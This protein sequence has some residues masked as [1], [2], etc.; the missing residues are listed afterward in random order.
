MKKVGR[1]GLIILTVSVLAAVQVHAVS[2]WRFG[3][4]VQLIVTTTNMGEV[5]VVRSTGEITIRDPRGIEFQAGTFDVEGVVHPGEAVKV[6]V[7]W[8]TSVA[9][10]NSSWVPGYFD[11]ILDGELAYANGEY[12][13][14]HSE[15]DDA[16]RL[17]LGSTGLN[18][19]PEI[20]YEGD[21]TGITQLS[22]TYYP[23]GPFMV[24]VWVENTGSTLF[25]PEVNVS[26]TCEDDYTFEPEARCYY[27]DE[28]EPGMNQ[29]L[30]E[31]E[32]PDDM[33]EGTCSYDVDLEMHC[34]EVEVTDEN[35]PDG[36]AGF[37]HD[38]Y[39][40]SEVGSEPDDDWY[41]F[42]LAEEPAFVALETMPDCIGYY[43]VGLYLY[44]EGYWPV[45]DLGYIYC[46]ETFYS[47]GVISETE[48]ETIAVSCGEDYP[49]SVLV[50]CEC[51]ATLGDG[52]PWEWTSNFGD[53]GYHDIVVEVRERTTTD[54]G[55]SDLV[56]VFVERLIEDPEEPVP[57]YVWLT[58]E[59]DYAFLPEFTLTIPEI[60][61]APVV[62]LYGDAVE[63]IAPPGQSVYK[64]E[65]DVSDIPPSEEG[66]YFELSVEPAEIYLMTLD[67]DNL[68]VADDALYYRFFRD[69]EAFLSEGETFDER[70]EAQ[71]EANSIWTWTVPDEEWTSTGAHTIYVEVTDD[72]GHPDFTGDRDRI[73][74]AT[75]EI[76][77]TDDNQVP[78]V[79]T[80]DSGED[81]GGSDSTD[82]STSTGTTGGTE[83]D[84][85]TL[86]EEE[87]PEE[88]SQGF[89]IQSII[90]MILSFFQNLFG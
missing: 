65:V 3:D 76:T 62:T 7:N 32:L 74:I 56:A 70:L 11:I 19:L 81:T 21:I 59:C 29:Y 87:A 26:F 57:L 45:D 24:L 2:E 63:N 58:N 25:I 77:I 79:G 60:D 14:T 6:P 53:E 5:D 22:D 13:E 41:Q 34:L 30:Y 68:D 28:C 89:S 61:D 75:L 84:T 43:D 35:Y 49:E 47:D 23:G 16:F 86:P 64:L 40:F 37:W 67:E 83:P 38:N 9:L 31:C 80:D 72:L 90:D 36:L 73:G 85:E 18:E 44:D 54:I 51:L 52:K 15:V 33:P 50:Y 78:E 10:L 27:E 71:G 88:E 55:A 4:T 46:L 12:E 48:M 42:S 20:V 1:L 69:N 82:S 8:D 66:Y 17:Y 39:V